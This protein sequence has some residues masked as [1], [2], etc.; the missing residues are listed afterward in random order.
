VTT[1]QRI[2]SLEV[3]SRLRRFL[4][5]VCVFGIAV[6]LMCVAAIGVGYIQLS[7]DL[8]AREALADHRWCALISTS[9]KE[10]RHPAP[11]QTA[12]EFAANK[13]LVAHLGQEMGCTK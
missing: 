8:K 9:L 1:E 4:I 7:S 10:A 3:V 13:A 2:E 12:K 6:V 11:G 5:F